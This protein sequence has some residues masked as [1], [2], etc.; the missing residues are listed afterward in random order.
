MPGNVW[1]WVQDWYWEVDEWY[2]SSSC[3]PLLGLAPRGSGR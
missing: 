2:C 1:E 3:W